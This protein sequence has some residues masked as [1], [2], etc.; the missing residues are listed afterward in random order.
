MI[1]IYK[2]NAFITTLSSQF[3]KIFHIILG[4]MEM[5][6]GMRRQITSLLRNLGLIRNKGPGC[7]R[8]LN[9]NSRNWSVIKAVVGAGLYPNFIKVND[10]HYAVE[11]F[12]IS[13]LVL[14][15][16]L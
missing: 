9:Q 5:V 14:V 8:D 2:C 11:G 3:D 7:M 13:W 12:L 1:N 10:P 16:Y 4:T 6:S 15:F